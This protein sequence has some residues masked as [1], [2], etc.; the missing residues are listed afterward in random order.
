MHRLEDKT[1]KLLASMFFAKPVTLNT[2]QQKRITRWMLKTAMAFE[3][4]G[5]QDTGRHP[6]YF[7]Q[8]ERQSLLRPSVILPDTRCFLARFK[9]P[10]AADIIPK[11]THGPHVSLNLDGNRYEMQGYS[12]TLTIKHLTLQVFVIRRPEHLV[13]ER[14]LIEIP[15][16]SAATV[17]LWPPDETTKT[18]NWPPGNLV[19][20]NVGLD[21]FA[22]RW[23]DATIKSNV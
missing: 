12:F 23:S 13:G 18:V 7:L 21:I 17:T 9:D 3:F 4:L 2:T 14:I 19:L 10:N 16:W 15:N 6:V 8:S 22:D 11:E 20:D 5:G 1:E